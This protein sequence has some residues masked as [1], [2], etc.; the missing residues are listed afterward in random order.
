MFFDTQV[1]CF[2]AACTMV[3][4]KAQ[5]AAD[6]RMKKF[7][8]TMRPRNTVLST[9][10]ITGIPAPGLQRRPVWSAETT[11]LIARTVYDHHARACTLAA[12]ATEKYRNDYRINYPKGRRR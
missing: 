8:T 12:T 4:C 2:T 5:F 6:G 3:M 11:D 1:N 7:R 9:E 10:T